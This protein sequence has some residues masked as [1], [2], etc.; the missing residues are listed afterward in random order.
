MSRQAKTN[1]LAK[2]LRTSAYSLARDAEP[3]GSARR[4]LL[5]ARSGGQR[6]AERHRRLHRGWRPSWKVWTSSRASGHAAKASV[7]PRRRCRRQQ[8]PSTTTVFSRIDHQAQGGI[9]QGRANQLAHTVHRQPQVGHVETRS[10]QPMA[11]TRCA[12]AGGSPGGQ[13]RSARRRDTALRPLVV[14]PSRPCTPASFRSTVPAFGSGLRAGQ[15][16]SDLLVVGT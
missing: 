5:D 10:Q 12:A 8:K 2:H 9:R 11:P 14:N 16:R 3:P 4:H 15:S 7:P 1:Q 6:D 13:Q